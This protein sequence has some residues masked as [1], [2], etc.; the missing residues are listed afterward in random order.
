MALYGKIDK[1]EILTEVAH[2][3]NLLGKKKQI[4]RDD[5]SLSLPLLIGEYFQNYKR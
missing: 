5:V 4:Q 1:F 3:T 2:V